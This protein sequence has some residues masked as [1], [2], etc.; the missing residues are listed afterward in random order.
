METK[1]QSILLL[2]KHGKG[3]YITQNG[4]VYDGMF[5]EDRPVV[6]FERF[7]NDMPF[8]FRLPKSTMNAEA[9]KKTMI[10]LNSIISRWSGQLRQFYTKYSNIT[11][12]MTEKEDRNVITRYVL[13]IILRDIGLMRYGYPIAEL[14]RAYAEVFQN[15]NIFGHKY[16]VS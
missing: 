6:K 4:R 3:K 14:D 5:E 16:Q 12:V 1:S 15:D 9:I 2:I 8:V 10:S 7:D 11:K 13:W